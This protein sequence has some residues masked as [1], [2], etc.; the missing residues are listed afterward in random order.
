MSIDKE[1]VLK[2][3]KLAR[4]K[5]DDDKV[6]LY[7]K[8]LSKIID[9]ID[10]LKSANTDNVAPM[11]NVNEESTPTRKDEVTDGD[12]TDKIFK[13]APKEKFEYFLVPKVIE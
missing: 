7:T 1:T 10:T 13:N 6:E 5:I 12:C 4:F 11:T 3:A 9:V 8:E 2:T